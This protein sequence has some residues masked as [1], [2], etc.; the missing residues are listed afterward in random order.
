MICKN[1]F[2]KLKSIIFFSIIFLS[3]S[4]T[5]G[6]RWIKKVLFCCFCE[7]DS[8]SEQSTVYYYV[9]ADDDNHNDLHNQ[10]STDL[11]S[12]KHS[13]KS[14][15]NSEYNSDEPQ[16]IEGVHGGCTTEN[17]DEKFQ[18]A[19][20][21]ISEFEEKND[22]NFKKQELENDISLSNESDIQDF[23]SALKNI[24]TSDKNHNFLDNK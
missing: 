15:E 4:P 21:V 23:S 8:Q 5:T 19:R 6:C 3:I 7:E 1:F 20:E 22:D 17:D 9:L 11:S 14:K 12:S 13:S 10:K 16:M 18:T 24:T 2:Q